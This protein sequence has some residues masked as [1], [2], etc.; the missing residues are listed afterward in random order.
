MKQVD[1][2][3]Q[4]TDVDAAGRARINSRE[5]TC[6]ARYDERDHHAH[7]QQGIADAERAHQR[8]CKQ[9]R[10]ALEKEMRQGLRNRS[11]A[12][13]QLLEQKGTAAQHIA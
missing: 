4:V 5:R 9:A 10:A 3:Q 11:Q 13:L 2:G 12:L 7:H 1:A 8:R 6:P